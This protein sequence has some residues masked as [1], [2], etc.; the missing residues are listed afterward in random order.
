MPRTINIILVLLL[1]TGSLPGQSRLVISKFGR[2]GKIVIYPE[3]VISFRLDGDERSYRS[4]IT[5]LK[6]S[7]II[8]EKYDVDLHQIR[9]IRLDLDPKLKNYSEVLIAAGT[10]FFLADM[11]NSTVVAGDEPSI[12]KGVAAIS[13]GLVGGGIFLRFVKRRN[14]NLRKKWRASIIE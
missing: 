6:D 13:T 5:G 4:T 2:S 9:S 11:I 14:F 10:I 1:A 8:F 3:T 7:T 12:N